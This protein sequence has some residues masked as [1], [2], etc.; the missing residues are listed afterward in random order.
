MVNVRNIVLS[1][2][3]LLNVIRAH[4]DDSEVST[5]LATGNKKFCCIDHRNKPS[6]PPNV[7]NYDCSQLVNF[8]EDRCE[9]VYGGGVCIWKKGKDC[10]P[11]LKCQRVPYYEQHYKNSVDVGRC[12][13]ACDDKHKCKPKTFG[14]VQIKDNKVV[15]YDGKAD[16]QALLVKVVRSCECDDCGVVEANKLIE[17]PV[18]KCEGECDS[19]QGSQE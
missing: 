3:A 17:I 9:S 15:D 6:S 19:L 14:Y 11:E 18:G 4:P 1:L 10:H 2:V 12:V 8:G 7:A 5:G 13:G 16:L